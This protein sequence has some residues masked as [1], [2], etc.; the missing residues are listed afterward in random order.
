MK[1]ISRQFWGTVLIWIGVIIFGAVIYNTVRPYFPPRSP[2]LWVGQVQSFLTRHKIERPPTAQPAGPRPHRP[3]PPARQWSKNGYL[4]NN[5]YQTRGNYHLWAWRIDPEK[6]T[7]ETVVAEV[8]HAAAG[9]KGGFWI[10]AYADT[11]GDDKPD[12]EIARSDYL[13]TEEPGQWSKF[14]FKTKEK[15]IF[16][17]STWPPGSNTWVYRGKGPWP[18]VNCPFESRGGSY[19]P[20]FFHTISA[21]DARSAGPAITNIKVSFSD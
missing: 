8:A 6:K 12:R 1:I 18:A 17:G 21:Q 19:A 11:D 4:T 15:R 5:I 14:E 3:P 16:V 20:L 2:Y 7:G 9:K 13:T 10:V